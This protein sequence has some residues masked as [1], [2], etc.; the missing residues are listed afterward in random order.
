MSGRESDA[1]RRPGCPT[2]HRVSPCFPDCG[3]QIG[4]TNQSKPD[5]TISTG[6]TPAI[7]PEARPLRHGLSAYYLLRSGAHATTTA[8][9]SGSTGTHRS[10]GAA[11]RGSGPGE[12][13]PQPASTTHPEK[14]TAA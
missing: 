12:P 2:M 13:Q 8:R 9:V 11:R 3:G 5:S 7:D 14:E 1:Y 10:A 6:E 4:H